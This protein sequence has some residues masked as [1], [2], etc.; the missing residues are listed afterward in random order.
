MKNQIIY[1][2]SYYL[3]RNNIYNEHCIKV[4]LLT[5][6]QTSVKNIISLT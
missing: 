6:I 3:H 4:S 2:I 1:I 5:T